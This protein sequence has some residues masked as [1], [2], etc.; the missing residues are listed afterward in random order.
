MMNR[1]CGND[2]TPL[3]PVTASDE[4]AWQSLTRAH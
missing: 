2:K 1:F 4:G 3:F